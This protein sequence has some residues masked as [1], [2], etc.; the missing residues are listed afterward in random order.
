MLH[1]IVDFANWTFIVWGMLNAVYL[2]IGAATKKW[3][4]ILVQNSGFLKYPHVYKCTQILGT[5]GLICFAWIFFRAH[6]ISDALIIIKRIFF[7]PCGWQASFSCGQSKGEFLVALVAIAVLEAGQLW[8]RG[9][10][11]RDSVKELPLCVRWAFY[12]LIIWSIILFGKLGA[13]KFIYFQF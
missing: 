4:R 7:G 3:R 5:F 2:I 10:D 8:S 12:Y 6:S 1:L 13:S 9:R 11:I